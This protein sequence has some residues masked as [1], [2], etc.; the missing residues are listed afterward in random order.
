MID[1]SA[2]ARQLDNSEHRQSPQGSRVPQSGSRHPCR[3]IL[4][5]CSYGLST[6]EGAMEQFKI[7]RALGLSFTSWFRNFIPFTLLA[8]VLYSPV[9]IWLMTRN[10]ASEAGAEDLL[11]N[12]FTYP[13]YLTIGTSML[14]PPLL[15]YRVIQELNGTTVSMWTSISFGLRGVPSAII[16]ALITNLVQLVPGVGGIVGAIVTCICFVTTPAAVA[17]RLNP[18]SAL[19]RSAALTRG[20][21]WGIFG[22]TF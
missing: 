11:D 2:I 6:Y 19:S 20:R 13:V 8:A 18:F 15:T 7:S 17:E 10:P 16:L 9:V 12:F 1:A 4:L 22:L 21:R 5:Y 14:V 3:A